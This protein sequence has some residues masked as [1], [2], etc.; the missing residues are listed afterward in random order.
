MSQ[1]HTFMS[2]F[3]PQ[4]T[5]Q[6]KTALKVAFAFCLAIVSALYFN[7]ERPYWSAM[8][9]NVLAISDTLTAGRKKARKRLIGTLFGAL[10]GIMLIANFAQ[11]PTWFL[12]A[13]VLL[14]ALCIYMGS[15]PVYG[16]AFTTGFIVCILLAISG[17]LEGDITLD[18]AILRLQETFLGLFI[19]SVVFNLIWPENEEKRFQ[20]EVRLVLDAA[21]PLHQSMVCGT[22]SDRYHLNEKHLNSVENSAQKALA[23]LL[24]LP[25][26]NDRTP[27]RKQLIHDHQAKAIWVAK[28]LLDQAYS[29]GLSPYEFKILNSAIA[30]IQ[31]SVLEDGCESLPLPTT[32]T[33][34]YQDNHKDNYQALRRVQYRWRERAR[35]TLV[36]SASFTS[37]ILFWLYLP[38]PSGTMF[39][40]NSAV[41]AAVLSNMPQQMI[42]HWMIGYMVFGVG[43]LIQYVLLMPAMTE[44]WQLLTFY[45]INVFVIY[46]TFGNP[47]WLV[48]RVLGGN[49]LLMITMAATKPIPVY[50]V[51]TPLNMLVYVMVA[52][53]IVRF[54]T[55]LFHRT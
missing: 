26:L 29:L 8:T 18:V 14:L 32:V 6:T 34:F 13:T 1:S 27:T 51:T 48:Y 54:Y 28:R 41:C 55:Q 2:P 35:N 17:G 39:I 50:E 23:D 4:L 44:V 24:S 19:Y 46:R 40:I 21:L 30:L 16:Y 38:I 53:T 31:Q 33:H 10:I 11:D 49:L 43:F 20:S 52:L 45:F 47:Q 37:A 22:T 5:D 25:E 36:G 12:A 9:V 3:V 15:D 42:K 7:L